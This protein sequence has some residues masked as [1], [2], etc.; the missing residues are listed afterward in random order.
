MRMRR[1][2]PSL[3]QAKSPIVDIAGCRNIFE[4]ARRSSVEAEHSLAEFERRPKKTVWTVER[5]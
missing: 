3:R 2:E 1:P 5:K 4:V